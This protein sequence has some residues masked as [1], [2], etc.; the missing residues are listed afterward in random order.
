MRHFGAAFFCVASSLLSQEKRKAA[1]DFFSDPWYHK[2][3]EIGRKG[4]FVTWEF[5]AVRRANVR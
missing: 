3:E 4:A 1:I 5:H 2:K